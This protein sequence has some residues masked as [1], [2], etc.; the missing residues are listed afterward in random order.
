MEQ[1]GGQ[2]IFLP[3]YSPDFSPSEPCW[4]KL[5]TFLRGVGARTPRR[6]L[7]ALRDALQTLTTEDIRGW[8]QHCGYPVTDN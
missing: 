5:K 8:F 3:T 7:Q 6:L 1:I 2:V 4:A